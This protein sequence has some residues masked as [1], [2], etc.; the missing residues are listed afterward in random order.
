MAYTHSNLIINRTKLNKVSNIIADLCITIRTLSNV[1][2][3]APYSTI[4]IDSIKYNSHAL[5][6][7]FLWQRKTHTIPANAAAQISCSAGI[8]LLKRHMYRPVMRQRNASPRTVIIALVP[9][10]R[11]L[12]VVEFP[13][14]IQCNICSIHTIFPPNFQ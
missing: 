7:I 11:Y 9:C 12:A 5:S 2:A 3:V 10:L 4:F 13:I 1:I 6:F 8:S 14:F